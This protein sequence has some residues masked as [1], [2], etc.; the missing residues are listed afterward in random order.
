MGDTFSKYDRNL[1][2]MCGIV[3]AVEEKKT[4]PTCYHD[5]VFPIATENS[6]VPRK[7][8]VVKTHKAEQNS[9]PPITHVITTRSDG[10]MLFQAI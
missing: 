9:L 7:R 10:K 8:R 3:I 1:D 5:D 2:K 6:K 4:K